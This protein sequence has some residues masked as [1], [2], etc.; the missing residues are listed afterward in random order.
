MS[1]NKIHFLVNK[2]DEQ[3]A[4]GRRFDNPNYYPNATTASAAV[5]CTK[6]LRVVKGEQAKYNAKTLR[7]VKFPGE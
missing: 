6:C 1:W 3:T 4:C 7:M 5:T 2:D